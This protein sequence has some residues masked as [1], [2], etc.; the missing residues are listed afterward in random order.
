MSQGPAMMRSVHRRLR[1]LIVA[2]ASWCATA[3]WLPAPAARSGPAAPLALSGAGVVD[4]ATGAIVRLDILVRGD[5][6]AEMVPPG[7]RLPEGTDV[8]DVAG[9]FAIPVGHAR[10]H[11]LCQPARSRT[12]IFP[13]LVAT[14]RSASA[15]RQ[16]VFLCSKR[17]DGDR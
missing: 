7:S 6:I 9:A 8:V 10:P 13:A 12:R 15:I 5:R 1:L 3:E 11:D 17:P 14:G 16:A 2:L 4:P